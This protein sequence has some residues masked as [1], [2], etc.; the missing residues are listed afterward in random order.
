M[1]VLVTTTTYMLQPHIPTDLIPIALKVF[2]GNSHNPE[3]SVIGRRSGDLYLG[4]GKIWIFQSGQWV[5][6]N[7]TQALLL[8]FDGDMLYATPCMTQGIRLVLTQSEHDEELP[9]VKRELC[10]QSNDFTTS[11][12]Q[13]IKAVVAGRSLASLLFIIIAHNELICTADSIN[14]PRARHDHHITKEK[15]E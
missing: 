13:L 5:T 10:Q 3:V 8:D 2:H 4:P 11:V 7:P 1:S 12:L 6:W 15:S 14:A 9:N